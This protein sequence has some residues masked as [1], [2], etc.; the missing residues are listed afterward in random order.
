[1][2]FIGF[3]ILE[4]FLIVLPTVLLLFLKIF[5][6]ILLV[7]TQVCP[8]YYELPCLLYAVIPLHQAKTK[9]LLIKH[10]NSIGLW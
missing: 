6:H 7:P 8:N 10:Y 3:A 5:R 9:L 1:M 2:L 4:L